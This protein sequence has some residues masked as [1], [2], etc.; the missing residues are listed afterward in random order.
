MGGRESVDAKL[1]EAAL[2]LGAAVV[3]I[4]YRLCPE[5][6]LPELVADV[7][8]G[9]RARHA[10]L[11]VPA[12][13]VHP[14]STQF[15]VPV[16]LLIAV[17]LWFLGSRG[18]GQ[19]GRAVAL[20]GRPRACGR[21]RQL[22]RRPPRTEHRFQSSAGGWYHLILRIRRPRGPVVLEPI[23]APTPRPAE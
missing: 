1:K 20:R 11:V 9:V 4:D 7:C 19:G 17:C 3:S 5:T 23:A 6:A 22:R 12:T 21:S 2:G 16:A 18:L 15:H 10:Q 8:D 13:P 14:S